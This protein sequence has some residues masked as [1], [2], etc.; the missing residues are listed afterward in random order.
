[1]IPLM[2]SLIGVVATLGILILDKM[3]DV[4]RRSV[5]DDDALLNPAPRVKSREE[6]RSTR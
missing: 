1:M 5:Y 2:V 4:T 3:D 6:P